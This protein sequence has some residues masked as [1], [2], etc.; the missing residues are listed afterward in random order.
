M[1][2]VVALAASFWLELEAPSTA[3]ITVA[4]LAAPTRGQA[5][6]KACCRLLATLIGHCRAPAT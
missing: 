3:A 6:E 5:L 2:V 4:I 1:A